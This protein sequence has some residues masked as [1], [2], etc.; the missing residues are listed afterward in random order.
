MRQEFYL[1]AVEDKLS[2]AELRPYTNLPQYALRLERDVEDKLSC[3]E[4]QPY[5]AE[6]LPYTDFANVSQRGENLI[7]SQIDIVN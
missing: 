6:V 3:A 4:L 1:R 5:C 2:Y 7:F